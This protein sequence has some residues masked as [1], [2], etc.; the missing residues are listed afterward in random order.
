VKSPDLRKSIF[1]KA[2]LLADHDGGEVV[3]WLRHAPDLDNDRQLDEWLTDELER[4]DIQTCWWCGSHAEY[5]CDAVLGFEHGDGEVQG[6]H[7][8]DAHICADCRTNLSTRHI[9]FSFQDDLLDS[10]DWCP[11]HT[12]EEED[13]AEEPFLGMESEPDRAQTFRGRLQQHIRGF[14]PERVLRELIVGGVEVVE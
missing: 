9:S 10:I 5:L 1:R 11:W 6:S 4:R 7:T 8:C 13:G 14:R 12:K 3:D 2:D